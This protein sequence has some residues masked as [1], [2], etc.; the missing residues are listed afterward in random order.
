MLF[1]KKH[2][3]SLFVFCVSLVVYS[4]TVAPTT[5]FWDCGEFIASAYRLQVPHPPGAPVYLLLA[6]F[7]SLFAPDTSQVALTVNMLSVTASAF[8]VMFLYKIFLLL[9]KLLGREVTANRPLY[10]EIS[11][12]SGTLLFA[13]TDSF[14]Y[15]AV[16]SEVYATSL[17][18]ST[19][20]LWA[21]LKWYVQSD[22]HPRLFFLGVYLLGLSIGVHL[23]NLLLVPVFVLL[24]VWKQR[25]HGVSKSIGAILSGFLLLAVLYWGLIANGLWPAQKFELW[26]VNALGLPI[27]SGLILF[28]FVL[29]AVHVA[30]IVFT[31]PRHR[32]V[33]FAFLISALILMGWFS[34]TLVPVRAHAGPPINMNAP[35]D[36]FSLN[37][38]INRTQYG[39]RP[40]IR[41]VHAGAV[42]SGWETDSQYVYNEGEGRYIKMGSN[43]L[44]HF[45]SEEKVWF[46][47]IYSR[48]RQH[49]EG[50]EWWTGTDPSEVKPDFIH[51]LS[52]FFR[53]QLGHSYL[54]YLIWNFAGRQNDS[55][56]HGDMLSGN[57]ASG[58]DFIDR[59]LLGSRKYPSAED[60][61]SAAANHYYLI[62]LI[63]ALAGLFFLLRDGP[64]RKRVL[65]LIGLMFLM[66]GPA[67]VLY[68][69]QP[70][71]EPRE[72]DYVYVAS[73]MSVAIFSG[74]GVYGILKAVF[75]LSGSVFTGILAGV[76]LFLAGAG[77]LF[78]VNLNDHDRSERFLARD[79][80]VSQLSSCP[81]NAILFTYGDNDTYPLWY[82]RQV[83]KVRPDVRLVNLGLLSM[84]WYVDHI[85]RS[86]PGTSGL[87][88]TLP[89]KFFRDNHLD[90]L[91]V[92][93]VSSLP[94]PGVEALEKIRKQ[95]TRDQE[96]EDIF[97][98]KLHPVWELTLPG[99]KILTWEISAGFISMGNLALYD[100]IAS[101]INDRPICFTHNLDVSELHGF[102]R[103]L[104]S[105]GLVWQADVKQKKEEEQNLLNEFTI[106]MDS[107]SIR[108]PEKT[109]YDNTCRQAL[110]ASGYREVTN[111]LS[112]RLLKAG[113]HQKA[114]Q[115]LNKSLDEWPY[116]PYIS[117]QPL[118]ETARLLTRSGEMRK[119]EELIKNIMYVNLQDVYYFV[120][121]GFDSREVKRRYC[122]LFAEIRQLAKE[123]EM[124]DMIVY[125]DMELQ[126][127][128]GF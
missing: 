38:Y 12:I 101:N 107:I 102:E 24:Y 28:V 71:F 41:G 111:D 15:S 48:Q 108:K 34:Y 119:A 128:C 17:L 25:D 97:N 4:V 60:I 103:F 84:P 33:H 104:V 1:L 16:E 39:S 45:N 51:Q 32:V 66:T 81:P 117:Q 122:P 93:N 115:L 14:W 89:H 30:G 5:S 91:S 6:R 36:V 50:Y 53:Y 21:F 120:Y 116:S 95:Y 8:T 74:I 105:R 126:S 56:G 98:G 37:E 69:N 49:I 125:I 2:A 92:S 23:L 110:A 99:Q 57:W 62:P 20:T 40:L 88:M 42:A 114:T 19:V 85:T 127:L 86:V 13:F 87:E 27:H 54:R 22:S 18:F 121:S 67:I 65:A 11:A 70:P 63:L 90:F 113:Y 79:L 109:W 9:F 44:F 31:F 10:E 7:F 106:F 77:L 76:F 94:L 83:E 61:Y 123:L 3:G 68:L 46:P 82:A 64:G 80:A 35:D 96:S 29:L 100:I 58:I 26:L 52:F 59:H 47:R 43:T 72:R 112:E 78:S 118:V 55:Q 75:R 124:K 73:F